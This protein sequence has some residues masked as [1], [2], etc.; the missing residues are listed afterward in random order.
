MTLLLLPYCTDLLP[1]MIDDGFATKRALGRAQ[2][3]RTCPRVIDHRPLLLPHHTSQGAA[4]ASF[5]QDKIHAL[6]NVLG[7]DA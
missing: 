7:R 2:L 3:S 5:T 4:A 1:V 6:G